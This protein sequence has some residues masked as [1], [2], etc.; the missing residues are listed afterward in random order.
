[1][2]NSAIRVVNALQQSEIIE[3]RRSGSQSVDEAEAV[4]LSALAGG[5]QPA[6]SPGGL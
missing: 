5:S 6:A 2:R 4:V 1:M 3:A